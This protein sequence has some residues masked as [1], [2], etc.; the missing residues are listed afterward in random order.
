M[1]NKVKP[2]GPGGKKRRRRKPKMREH[3]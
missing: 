1:I 2:K 3:S